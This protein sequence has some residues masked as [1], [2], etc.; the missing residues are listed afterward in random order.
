MLAQEAAI[1][2]AK[3]A[4]Q[5]EPTFAPILS[6][7]G[8]PAPAPAISPSL[9]TTAALESRSITV[10]KEPTELPT[11]PPQLQAQLTPTAQK[12]LRE[13][14]KG[15]TNTEREVEERSV[16]M[17]LDAAGE[18]GIRVREVEEGR[19]RRREEGRGTAGDTISGWFGW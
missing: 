6:P 7:D 1:E 9:P 19:K 2:S 10:A 11:L 15:M 5:T 16:Q 14:L 8:A 3:A 17:E 18:I 12:A 13:R 4:G